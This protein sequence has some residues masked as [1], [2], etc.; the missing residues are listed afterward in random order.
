[1]TA[2]IFSHE[3]RLA[4]TR[5]KMERLSEVEPRTLKDMLKRDV[6]GNEK[7]WQDYFSD[8]PAAPGAEEHQDEKFDGVHCPYCGSELR[9][10]AGCLVCPN[11]CY[12]RC[13]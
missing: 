13:G 8:T 12:S 5:R 7:A 4:I 9:H 3:E 11:K 6:Q 1:M 2:K 10:E